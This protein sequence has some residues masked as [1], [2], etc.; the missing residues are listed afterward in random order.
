MHQSFHNPKQEA[1]GWQGVPEI[2]KMCIGGRIQQHASQT[3][4]THFQDPYTALNCGSAENN[5]ER[6][7]ERILEHQKCEDVHGTGTRSASLRFQI[8]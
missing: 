4:L 2:L 8:K 3:E 5:R 1:L 6:E 7:V